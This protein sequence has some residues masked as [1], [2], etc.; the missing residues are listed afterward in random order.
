MRLHRTCAGPRNR[1]RTS[2][3]IHETNNSHGS[4]RSE[5]AHASGASSRRRDHA[6]PHGWPR[7]LH[8]RHLA[9]IGSATH[10]PF[11]AVF[12]DGSTYTNA[13]RLSA[14]PALTI[15]FRT[16]RAELRVIAFGH[17]GLLES[18]FDGSVDVDGD[19]ALAFRAA[20]DA[21]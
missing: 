6:R 2:S 20:M 12:A 4:D 15:T 17:V 1:S 18:Y 11:R 7:R 5:Q 3:P 21:R 8:G 19:L 9:R 16:T 10:V 13:E 14:P